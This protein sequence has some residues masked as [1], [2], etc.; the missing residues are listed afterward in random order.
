MVVNKQVAHN[1]VVQVA[2]CWSI[3]RFRSEAADIRM[4]LASDTLLPL[5]ALVATF[6]S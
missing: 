2:A 6:F 4:S 5:K 3:H 1:G